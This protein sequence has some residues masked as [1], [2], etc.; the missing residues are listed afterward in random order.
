MTRTT[1]TT[2]FSYIVT[3]DKFTVS[4]ERAVLLEDPA[5]PGCVGYG[6]NEPEALAMLVAARE[7]Y[8]QDLY[9]NVTINYVVEPTI[10]HESLFNSLPRPWSVELVTA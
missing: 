9:G 7:A 4:G 6:A 3:E 10:A 5:L 8:L 2:S 1:T